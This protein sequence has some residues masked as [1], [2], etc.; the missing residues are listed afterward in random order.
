MTQAE[1]F[2][3]LFLYG[4]LAIFA[5]FLITVGTFLQFFTAFV[6]LSAKT[7]LPPDRNASNLK[8]PSHQNLKLNNF[9]ILFQSLTY[10][11]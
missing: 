2:I 11:F 8:P 7:I 6:F 9:Q 3:V 4:T 10:S 1:Y 5:I